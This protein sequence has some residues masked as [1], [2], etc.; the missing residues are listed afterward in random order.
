MRELTAAAVTLM[1]G[2]GTVLAAESPDCAVAAHLAA[3][4]EYPL[5]RVAA[6]V[7]RA[8]TLDIVVM[9]AGSSTLAGPGGTDLAYPARLQIVLSKRFPDV[10]TKVVT[11]VKSRRSAAEMTEGFE[12]VLTEEKPVLVIWQSGTV[13]AITG[14]DPDDY[15]ATLEEGVQLLQAGGADVVLVNMQYS[16]RT[17]SMIAIQAYADNMRLVAQHREVPLLDRF[18]IMRHWSE[19]G[20]FDLST[21]TRKLET[22]ARIHDC[23]AQLLADV[24]RDGIKLSRDQPKP[25]Q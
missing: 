7:D 3:A 15:R 25:I 5:P 12:K 9:G 6:A 11:N 13:D 22:A 10:K 20:T 21:A 24:I 14:V 4:S 18:A 1:A 19:S 2:L 23:L 17:E 16:P 8:R